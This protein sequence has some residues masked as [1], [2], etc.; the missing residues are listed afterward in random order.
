MPAAT[1]LRL[2]SR[3]VLKSDQTL[4]E[5]KQ[6]TFIYRRLTGSES[7]D[8]ADLVDGINDKETP[9]AS[10]EKAFSAV[11]IG[12]V[13]LANVTDLAGK[14]LKI[15]DEIAWQEILSV[16]EAMELAY[17]NFAEQQIVP[18]DKKKSDSQSASGTGRSAK[19]AKGRK[20]VRTNPA[21]PSQ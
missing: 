3:I 10:L 1:D 21:P 15:G 2:R 5:E 6:P 16:T 4:P 19:G 9:R 12:L 8:L 13:G 14:E 17:R 7:L 18:D 11:M 20:S